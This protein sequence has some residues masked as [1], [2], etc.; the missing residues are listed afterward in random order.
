MGVTREYIFLGIAQYNN[1]SII[2]IFC[3]ISLHKWVGVCE[4]Y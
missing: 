3:D 2:H 1:E 4:L